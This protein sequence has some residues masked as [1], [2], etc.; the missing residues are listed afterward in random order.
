MSNVVINPFRFAAPAGPFTPLD[1]G[2]AL[3]F[4]WTADL[5][6]TL[7]TP[8][9]VTSWTDQQNS[10]TGTAPANEPHLVDPSLNGLP[11]ID[12]DIGNSGT[13]FKVTSTPTALNNIWTKG[14]LTTLWVVAQW[15]S[16]AADGYFFDKGWNSPQVGWAFRPR[17]GGDFQWRM[18]GASS[19]QERNTAGSFGTSN[20]PYYLQLDWDGDLS[21]PPILSVNGTITAWTNTSG[22]SGGLND[23]SSA[24]FVIGN[25]D[26]NGGNPILG[27]MHEFYATVDS[28]IPASTDQA[29]LESRWGFV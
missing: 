6:T 23:D 13:R 20:S 24:D 4:W 10:I 22:S 16:Q 15:T 2:S 27:V 8:P 26:P 9:N 3:L 21:T 25:R 18:R 17:S 14:T 7:G 1:H 19:N 29:Y 12:Y 11:G 5:G 28:A